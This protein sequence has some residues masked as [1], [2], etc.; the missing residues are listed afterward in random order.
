MEWSQNISMYHFFS[1]YQSN[2]NNFWAYSKNKE[3]LKILSRQL[4]VE[5]SRKTVK[6]VLRADVTD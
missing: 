3:K 6:I 1:P 2:L 4:S 5:K